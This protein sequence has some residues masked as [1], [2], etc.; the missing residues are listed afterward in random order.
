[1]LTELAS[2]ITLRAWLPA[3]G[4]G[5]GRCGTR[6]VASTRRAESGDREGPDPGSPSG[7]RASRPDSDDLRTTAAT[8]GAALAEPKPGDVG[9]VE[10]SGGCGVLAG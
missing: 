2:G 5:A 4:G 3:G 6:C 10:S 7:P 8:S 1:L 9:E